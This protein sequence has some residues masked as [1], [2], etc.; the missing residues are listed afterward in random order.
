M[1]SAGSKTKSRSLQVNPANAEPLIWPSDQVFPSSEASVKPP[2]GVPPDEGILPTGEKMIALL[3]AI[4]FP[5][6][7]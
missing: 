7:K 1:P 3:F 2:I 5:L 4:A 6:S